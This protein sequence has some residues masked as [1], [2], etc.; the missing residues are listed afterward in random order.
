MMPQTLIGFTLYSLVCFYLSIAVCWGA[1]MPLRY[2]FKELKHTS[3]LVFLGGLSIISFLTACYFTHGATTLWI[4]P[5]V[6]GAILLV[7]NRASVSL[8]QILI[9]KI[10]FIFIVLIPLG[11]Y[12]FFYLKAVVVDAYP[13]FISGRDHIFYSVVSSFLGE[14]KMESTMYDWIL[15]PRKASPTPYHYLELWFNTF[16]SR[17][18]GIL[19]LHTF[20]F[21]TIPVL[22]SGLGY[23]FVGHSRL[24][25]SDKYVPI[26]AFFSLMLLNLSFIPKAGPGFFAEPKLIPLIGLL[27]IQW[28]LWKEKKIEILVLSLIFYP[29]FNLT[30]IFVAG[31][32]SLLIFFG[33]LL[34]R[35]FNKSH[36]ICYLIWVGLLLGYFLFYAVF[37]GEVAFNSGMSLSFFIDYYSSGFMHF[38]KAAH[39]FIKYLYLWVGHGFLILIT[40]L[41]A[42][43][44]HPFA[45]NSQI[46]LNYVYI[47]TALG[48]IILITEIDWEA[49]PKYARMIKGVVF[50]SVLFVL[51][52]PL[53]AKDSDNALALKQT[54]QDSKLLKES[55]NTSEAK[56]VARYLKPGDVVYAYELYNNIQPYGYYLYFMADHWVLYT[57][58]NEIFTA[59]SLMGLPKGFERI[60]SSM[61]FYDYQLKDPELLS[62]NTFHKIIRGTREEKLISLMHE[63]DT[64][65]L[66]NM[67]L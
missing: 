31:G 22:Y 63:I 18:S 6:L 14:M 19:H 57:M 33:V 52:R 49:K 65:I 2:F 24:T 4:L 7:K 26:A 9:N 20:E 53:F 54:F 39:F 42:A 43:I 40:A 30:S 3:P 41:T 55:Q 56:F 50:C 5:L 32:L 10:P 45:E 47:S 1:G 46:V 34:G 8:P 59:D 62:K 25:K 66:I 23:L 13:F 58:N 28:E 60:S 61:N 36:L 64:I 44:T 51:V 12:L 38:K 27:L 17:S 21:I 15:E 29:L 11:F 16:V 35:N 48:F 37:K 67:P